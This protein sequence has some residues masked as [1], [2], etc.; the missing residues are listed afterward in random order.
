MT[1]LY[2]VGFPRWS[3]EISRLSFCCGWVVVAKSMP[4][5]HTTVYLKTITSMIKLLL[6]YQA[7]TV[8]FLTVSNINSYLNYCKHT[9]IGLSVTCVLVKTAGFIVSFPT[10]A[11]ELIYDVL[12]HIVPVSVQLKRT[13][14]FYFIL[15]KPRSFVFCFY[16]KSSI[17]LLASPDELTEKSLESVSLENLLWSK[18]FRVS[19]NK[20]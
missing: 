19:L 6:C 7:E 3:P 14:Y 2:W 5:L 16:P 1:H 13:F 20:I 4:Y 10:A 18:S 8:N 15:T 9:N 12:V 11:L 17:S